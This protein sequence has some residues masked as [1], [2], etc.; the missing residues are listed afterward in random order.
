MGKLILYVLACLALIS[1]EGL[2]NKGMQ[3]TA[4][5]MDEAYKLQQVQID[6]FKQV[7][8]KQRHNIADTALAQRM[9][10]L[11]GIAFQLCALS[12]SLML[13]NKNPQAYYASYAE[14][15]DKFR[16]YVVKNFDF[17]ETIAAQMGL[18]STANFK[19]GDNNSNTP[20]NNEVFAI[21]SILWL[22]RP[23]I[24]ST[25]VMCGNQNTINDTLST[26]EAA[27]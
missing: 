26:Q 13:N 1:C 4:E 21:K 5:K 9:D 15:A 6:S 27:N 17:T 3:M 20:G 7:I 24:L 10:T 25:V 22:I 23:A 2:I 12:D 16:N 18:I 11:S 19:Q 14:Q 8:L